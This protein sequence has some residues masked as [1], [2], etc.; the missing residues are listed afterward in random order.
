MAD[1]QANTFDSSF[2]ESYIEAFKDFY[3]VDEEGDDGDKVDNVDG[4][5]IKSI[6]AKLPYTK[7][8]HT[9]TDEID[10]LIKVCMDDGYVQVHVTEVPLYIY[11]YM[12]ILMIL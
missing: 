7:P 8:D 4:K 9:G 10:A 2:I 5:L 11:I 12:L 6:H 3:Q 1:E